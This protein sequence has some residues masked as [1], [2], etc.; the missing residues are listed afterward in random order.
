MLMVFTS[1]DINTRCESHIGITSSEFDGLAAVVTC[2]WRAK[3][4]LLT[5]CVHPPAVPHPSR[6]PPIHPSPFY[7]EPQEGSQEECLLSNRRFL[8]PFVTPSPHPLII[9][10]P[11]LNESFISC[12]AFLFPCSTIPR[13]SPVPKIPR[14]TSVFCF[15]F[16]R[17]LTPCVN[18]YAS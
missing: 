5:V 8:Q 16:H 6:Q 2:H 10:C 4:S 14:S 13:C 9:V 17:L 12:S 15:L 11:N 1:T 7:P 3:G 18:I